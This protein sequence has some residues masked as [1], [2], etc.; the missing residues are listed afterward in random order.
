MKGVGFNCFRVLAAAVLVAA[1]SLATPL[2]DYVAKPDTNYAY[3]VAGVIDGSGYTAYN[4]SMVSQQWRCGS[5]VDRPLWRH[6]LTVIKPDEVSGSTGLLWISNG[7]IGD[8]PP[9]VDEGFAKI[10]VES[11]TVVAIVKDV[12]NQPLRFKDETFPRSEDDI[13][14]YTF[15]KYLNGGD[16]EW[17][18]LLPMVKSVVR[19]MD[20]VNRHIDTVT[21][22]A[23]SVEK[24]VLA[25]GSK[26]GWAT[27]LAGAADP[28]VAAIA[29]AVIDVLRLDNQMKHHHGAYGFYS[30]A[31][32][33]Y[34]KMNIFDRLGSPKGKE[35]SAIVDPYSYI[36]RLNM[37]KLVINGSGDQFFLPDSSR[38]YFHDLK[39]PKF[40]RYVPNADHG[41]DALGPLAAFYHT[42][43]DSR[44]MPEF[45]WSISS[46][47][48]CITVR[49]V[50]SPVEVKVWRAKNKS[51]RD[52]RLETI[53]SK[54]RSTSLEANKNGEYVASVAMPAKG[55]T[56]FFV[57]L[58]FDAGHGMTHVLTTDV[59][60]VPNR[61]PHS[62]ER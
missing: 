36:D 9:A 60:V 62:Q 3:H 33:P 37:P 39:G 53:G 14:A 1:T 19:A 42:I 27:W 12:P 43:L 56:A 4:L 52:F 48:D 23:V 17:L 32:A 50:T 58:V 41:L 38:F 15:D 35:L 61:L 20:T 8:G 29:P 7:V 47:G 31:I 51:A 16:A 30:D 24:F 13:I 55:W 57:E 25:G 22:G 21:S 44:P 54:W 10:A 59:S 49:T 26:R 6:W 2:D 11:R 46:D 28:R 45:S 34:E 18:L 40:L 5:E